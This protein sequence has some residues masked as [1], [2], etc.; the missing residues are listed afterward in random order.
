VGD[1]IESD[2]FGLFGGLLFAFFVEG[3]HLIEHCAI[4]SLAVLVDS[5]LRH[6]CADQIAI[7][8]RGDRER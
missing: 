4:E 6:G 3:V 1:E 2:C 5:E 8:V 7:K